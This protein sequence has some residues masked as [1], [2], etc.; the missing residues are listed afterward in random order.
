M[1]VYSQYDLK[2]KRFSVEAVARSNQPTQVS[3]SSGLSGL[4][5]CKTTQSSFMNFVKDEYTTLPEVPDR[6]VR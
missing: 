2:P 3:I 4:K 5:V 1:M 6:V